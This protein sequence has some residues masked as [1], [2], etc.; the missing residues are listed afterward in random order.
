[1][2]RKSPR[3]AESQEIKAEIKEEDPSF[4]GLKVKQQVFFFIFCKASIYF[5]ACRMVPSRIL[6]SKRQDC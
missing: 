2:A 5:I 4:I 1:M 6:E 3:L